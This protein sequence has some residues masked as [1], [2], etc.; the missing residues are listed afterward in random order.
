MEKREEGSEG[1]PK[2]PSFLH[3]YWCH[4]YFYCLDFI[5]CQLIKMRKNHNL[6]LIIIIY[7]E[8]HVK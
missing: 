4:D 6:E 1:N 2:D 3:L 8:L 5:M 7:G